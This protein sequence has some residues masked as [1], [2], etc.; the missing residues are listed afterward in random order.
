MLPQ[1]TKGLTNIAMW[2]KPLFV[3]VFPHM[4][5]Y[6][7]STHLLGCV[8]TLSYT[9][10][11]SCEGERIWGSAPRLNEPETGSL[12]SKLTCFSC[13]NLLYCKWIYWKLGPKHHHRERGHQDSLITAFQSSCVTQRERVDPFRFDKAAGDWIGT[14]SQGWA[15]PLLWATHPPPVP[16]TLWVARQR[17][18]YKEMRSHHEQF[19]HVRNSDNGCIKPVGFTAKS[20]LI[21]VT[22]PE[23]FQISVNKNLWLTL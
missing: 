16:F 6:M 13:N 3:F 8:F 17:N 10:H 20:P 2:L 14:A 18:R 9:V 22:H 7:V 11:C 15:W 1:Q 4:H 21:F 19:A 5:V 12:N 23:K